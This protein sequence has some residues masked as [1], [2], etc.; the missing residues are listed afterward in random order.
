MYA[1]QVP[2]YVRALDLRHSAEL[3]AA[4]AD[5]VITAT[6]ES[7]MALGT[8]ML[9]ELGARPKDLAGLTRALRKQL[10]DRSLDMKQ[11]LLDKSKTG[12]Q[13]GSSIQLSDVFVFDQKAVRKSD[14][15]S[16]TAL[17]TE[18]TNAPRG[19]SNAVALG[20]QDAPVD[21]P[22]ISSKLNGN[23][24][25]QLTKAGPETDSEILHDD[26]STQ[27]EDG[28]WSQSDSSAESS[29][30]NSDTVSGAVTLDTQE[31]NMLR[32]GSESCP[33]DSR[34]A[35]SK[36]ASNLSSTDD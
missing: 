22:A 13:D 28:S 17:Q 36:T 31:R 23:G 12:G 4:G 33:V 5:K 11:Q 2:I 32:D 10:D 18:G 6:T 7:G 16:T 30:S 21:Q 8:L 14:Q 27:N 3:K 1:T 26:L 24:S 9:Q 25:H 15:P 34:P 20:V 29:S 19:Q 35:T